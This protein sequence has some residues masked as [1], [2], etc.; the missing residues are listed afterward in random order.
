MIGR[1][2]GYYLLARDWLRRRHQ[3]DE[4]VRWLRYANAG[5]LDPGNTWSMDYAIRNLPSGNPLVEIGS[6]AGLSANVIC[7]LL[8]KHGRGNVFFT[9]DNWDVTGQQL[10]GRIAE[11]ELAFSDYAEYV[12]AS[13]LRN[14]EFFSPRNRP[15]TIQA[16]STEFFEKWS[17]GEQLTDVFGRSVRLGGPISFCYVDA[18]HSCEAVR[19]EFESIDRYLDSGGFILFD[20]SSVSSPFELKR[21]MPEIARTGRYELVHQNPN[22]LFRKR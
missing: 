7:H 17:R 21:L 13:Y 5:S 18:L 6:F 1:L 22:F 19:R 14:V 20:D 12:K 2:K 3:E 15:H 10:T 16:G 11:S 8:R 4:F 9:C